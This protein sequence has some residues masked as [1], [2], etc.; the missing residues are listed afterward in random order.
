MLETGLSEFQK[1]VVTVMKT[2]Y[3]KIK[4]KIVN[5][6]KYKDNNKL[7]SSNRFR[8]VLK[9]D[10]S[11]ITISKTDERFGML[12]G[13]C[14]KVLHRFTHRKGKYI[15]GSN[16]P[17]INKNLSTENNAFKISASNEKITFKKG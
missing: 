11:K 13:V 6:R 12:F 9:T 10:L 7:L 3:C 8:K 15:R 16:T 14:Q 1:M 4:G 17:S 5:Y 2:G